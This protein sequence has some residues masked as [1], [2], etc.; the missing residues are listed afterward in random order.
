[1]KSQTHKI[2][3]MPNQIEMLQALFLEQGF[4]EKTLQITGEKVFRVE[5]GG[6][7]HYRRESGRVY[8]S[9]TTFLDAVMPANRFLNGW[10]EKMVAE[11]GSPERVSE[12][13]TA[14]ADYGTALHIATA[15]YC[16]N[17]GVNWQEFEA[18]AVDYLH[19][20]GIAVDSAAAELTKDFAACLQFFHD[21]A[22]QVIAVEI[23]VFL[24]QGIATLI[25]LAV[26]MDAK[27]Y[28]KTP[29]EKR[30]RIR[31]IINVKSGKGG[32]YESHVL[33]L[34]GERRMFNETFSEAIGYKIERVYNL[35]PKDW[36]TAPT[37]TIKDQTAAADAKEQEFSL[38]VQLATARGILDTPNRSFP[39]FIG[40]TKYGESPVDAMR[41]MSYDDFSTMKISENA[42]SEKV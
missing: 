5:I 23:P 2:K 11:L 28:D 29:A 16:R 40:Q 33:Q 12:Y 38:L 22:V 15:D 34:V 10:R 25:D 26:E 3:D 1:M 19:A 18:W 36:T 30:E 31:A 9:L 27:N 37:Y 17:A 7:R 39:V 21:Y 24:D 6:L 8:K 42:N 4:A 13:V 20:A 35:A 32:F 14:T 41:I